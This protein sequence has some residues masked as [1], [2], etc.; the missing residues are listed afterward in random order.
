MNCEEYRAAY[1]AGEAGGDAARHLEGCPSCRAQQGGL[2]EVAGQLDDAAMWDEPSPFVEERIVAGI[3]GQADPVRRAGRRWLPAAAAAAA[4]ALI[5]GAGAIGLAIRGSG[6]DWEVAF[7]DTG[8]ALGTVQGWSEGSGTRVALDVSGLD[9]APDGFVYE[10][11]FS[12][13]RVHVSG[14]TFRS[15]EGVELWVGVSRRD[16]PRIWVTLEPVDE[17]STPSRETVLDTDPRR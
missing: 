7:A 15:P 11:W 16:Y 2:A 12:A 3:A 5:I 9:P 17:D 8:A 14:G 4:L 1:L 10:L 13:D 6:P